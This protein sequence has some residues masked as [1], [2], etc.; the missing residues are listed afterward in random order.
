M[1]CPDC[2]CE[3]LPDCSSCA[4]CSAT[5]VARCP[6]TA[7]DGPAAF[8]PAQ[9]RAAVPYPA[10]QAGERPR[11]GSSSTAAT[12]F[13]CAGVTMDPELERRLLEDVLEEPGRAVVISPG[14]DLV[15]VLKYALAAHRRRVVRDVILVIALFLMILTFLDGSLVIILPL[16]ASWLTVVIEQF[17]RT[18]GPAVRGLRAGA[19]DPDEVPSPTRNVVHDLQ[20]Q[21]IATASATG[22]VTL[23]SG[24]PPFVGYGQVKESWSFAIDITRPR[25]D[26]RSRSFSVHEIYDSVKAGLNE[27]DLPGIDVTERLFVNGRDIRGDGR[28][29]P[30]PGGPPVTSVDPALVRELMANPE[31]RARPYLTIGMTG[32]G[33][34]LVGT[35]FIRFLLSRTDLFVEAAHTAIGPI[36]EQFKAIDDR[37]PEPTAGE[38][39]GLLLGSM[40]ALPALILMSVRAV[41]REL[42]AGRRRARKHDRVTNTGDY[43]PLLSAREAAA[44]SRWHRYFQAFDDARYVKVIEQRIFRTL[45]EFLAEHGVDTSSLVARTET[46]VNNGVMVTGQAS[47]QADQIAAGAGAQAAGLVSRLRATEGTGTAGGSN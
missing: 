25:Q 5:P 3:K 2:G 29:L 13:L 21:R 14:L 47:V 1:L 19:F 35:T 22:N 26:S 23:Y 18:H 27:L 36:R 28:F 4:Q 30:V 44:D 16:I 42:T 38:I 20:L 39:I 11:D 40:F 43:G 34:D 17:Q 15:T 31:E 32:W 9:R 46:V 37:N 45:L 8:I 41:F 24:F 33:G 6:V 7:N 10:G 12:R